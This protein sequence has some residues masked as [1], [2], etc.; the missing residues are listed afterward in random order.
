MHISKDYGELGE[1][2]PDELRE[3]GRLLDEVMRVFERNGTSYELTSAVA[4]NLMSNLMREPGASRA[5]TAEKCARLFQ[6]IAKRMA[7]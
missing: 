2:D 5:A 7:S 1:A 6:A 4:I 3:I